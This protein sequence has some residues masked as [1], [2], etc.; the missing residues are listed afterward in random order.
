M[1]VW[2]TLRAQTNKV[3]QDNS[4]MF[5][6]EKSEIC[7]YKGLGLLFIELCNLI[8]IAK[9]NASTAKQK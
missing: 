1:S 7:V 8:K 6:S 4:L 3:W 2:L 9:T 5:Y